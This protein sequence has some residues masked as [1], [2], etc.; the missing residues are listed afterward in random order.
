MVGVSMDNELNSLIVKFLIAIREKQEECK[1]KIKGT[2]D[3]ESLAFLFGAKACL[4]WCEGL[5]NSEVEE[6]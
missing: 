5:I 4:Y 2:F 3:K 1:L 6:E